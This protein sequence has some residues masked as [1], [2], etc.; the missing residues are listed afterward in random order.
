MMYPYELRSLVRHVCRS[1]KRLGWQELVDELNSGSPSYPVVDELI[2]L[3]VAKIKKVLLIDDTM[4]IQGS[5]TIEC[6]SD[7]DP[8]I[9]GAI[10]RQLEK[11]LQGRDH[12]FHLALLSMRTDEEILST[13]MALITLHEKIDET[14]IM[15]A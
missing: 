1:P 9:M 7:M 8:L 10:C 5:L 6:T 15:I 14:K 12:Q 4:A 2:K 11:I 13:V 3:C